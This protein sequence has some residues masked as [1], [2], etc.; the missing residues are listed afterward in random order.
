MLA[1]CLA[2]P[3]TPVRAQLASLA[4]DIGIDTETTASADVSSLMAVGD[5]V[6]FVATSRTLGR[7]LWGSDGTVE[8]TEPLLDGVTG[9][10]SNGVPVYHGAVGGKAIWSTFH[11]PFGNGLWATDGT[12]AGTER[13]A[14]GASGI[15]TPF[16][17]RSP[18]A[19]TVFDGK[20]LFTA[21][22]SGI[23]DTVWISDGTLAG[24]APLLSAGLQG[25]NPAWVTSAGDR[26]W[27]SASGQGGAQ[28]LFVTD[29]TAAGTLE[30]PGVPAPSEL[31][32]A[33]GNHLVFF[34]GFD[35]EQLW[36][37][38]GTQTGTR[39]IRLLGAQPQAGALT[40][41]KVVGGRAF[42]IAHGT[43]EEQELWVTDG[44]PQGTRLLSDFT[45]PLPF[46]QTPS[47]MAG[48]QA[49]G[50]AV[51]YVAA[52]SPAD[53]GLWRTDLTTGSRKKLFPACSQ[54]CAQKVGPKLQVSAGRLF[55]SV[56]DEFA[57]PAQLWVT[58]GTT[59]GTRMLRDDT[60][61]NGFLCP[62]ERVAA[63]DGR[64]YFYAAG[65]AGVPQLWRTD[66]TLS[67]TEPVTSFAGSSS[68]SGGPRVAAVGGEVYFGAED[69]VHG[70]EL[71]TLAPGAGLPRLVQDLERS[72]GDGDPV[73][74]TD[75]GGTLIF[76][77][78][79]DNDLLLWASDGSRQNTVPVGGDVL[80]DFRCVPTP[81]FAVS[82][83]AEALFVRDA[84]SG[85]RA[86][87]RTDGTPQGTSEVLD[88][89]GQT[90]RAL[91]ASDPLAFL[92]EEDFGS[93]S[94]RLWRTDGTA[95]GTFV[96]HELT[97]FQRFAGLSAAGGRAWFIAPVGA[98]PATNQLWVS[99]GTVG[100]THP[101]TDS[102]EFVISSNEP[103]KVVELDGSGYVVA[104][105][106]ALGLSLWRSDG[107]VA[108]TGPVT[109]PS[110]GFFVTKPTEIAAFAGRVYFTGWA[111]G[112]R[113]LLRSDGTAA[114]TE[115]FAL[116]EPADNYVFEEDA[117]PFYLTVLG[118]QMFFMANDNEHGRELWVSDGT[119]A[120]TRMVL[121]IQQGPFE[122]RIQRIA[123]AGSRVWFVADDGLHGE[124][125]WVSDGTAQ[126]T[127][128]VQDLSPGTG[129]SA[130]EQLTASGDRLYF[131]ADDGWSGREL[132]SVATEG[133]AGCQPSARYLCL[134]QGRFRVEASWQDFQNRIG[135][136]TAVP[137]TQDTGYFWFFRDTNVET[138]VKVLNGQPINGHYWTFFGALTNV[139]YALTVT[140]GDTGLTRRYYNPPR[141]F[142]S[143]GDT[144]SFGPKGAKEAVL[145]VPGSAGEP[146]LVDRYF[147]PSALKASCAAGPHQLC[148]NEDRFSVSAEWEDF[149]GKTGVG[150]A[151]PLTADTGYFWFFRD[152]NVEVVLKV[153]DGRPLNG[154]FWVFY[155]ALSNVAYRLTVTDTETGEVKIYENPARRFASVGDTTAFVGD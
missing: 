112:R 83:G 132:W 50:D 77:A 8:G 148:L 22:R 33:V 80:F 51:Y 76:G 32:A 7:Q 40:G 111:E 106:S 141:R 48:V 139:E 125:L 99:D 47:V 39:M 115:V 87:W 150:T 152:T 78:C 14:G 57:R 133:P 84:G 56:E 147:D 129:S 142:A 2:L 85:Q 90:V 69:G 126:G 155:G 81:R 34:R 79:V 63:A 24:T 38:D 5:R 45:A 30:V 54:N 113:A 131:V 137:L 10:S 29:G 71:W 119:T 72:V 108:T 75:A 46:G 114:G 93:S 121:D 52:D 67:G 37:S 62:G 17:G 36:A 101:V 55:F 43:T 103:L 95:A 123:A 116:F 92:I 154:N 144:E 6:V 65:A 145:E 130:P 35:A 128:L 100:G 16:D 13:L 60:C 109:G 120:G 58:D 140:D 15:V 61:V 86:L 135:E 25:N 110:P 96:I 136:G 82:L 68:L 1:L 91:E 12:R 59:G 11:G 26:G 107:T 23:F 18:L 151:V 3:A 20:V 27:F 4:R 42:F 94:A 74:L 64:L 44:T 127:R 117:P 134:N 9:A 105:S 97:D 146:L 102:Q 122:S 153:L 28:C 88:L 98:S 124:E 70:V 41:F 66:G 49:I 118:N 53:R 73:H 21:E 138:V 149:Q 19:V 89:F 31:F 143:V 104:R